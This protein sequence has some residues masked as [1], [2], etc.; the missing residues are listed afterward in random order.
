MPI[1]VKYLLSLKR[2]SSEFSF[3]VKQK[4]NL[5]RIFIYFLNLFYD[6]FL[7]NNKNIEVLNDYYYILMIFPEY[8]KIRQKYSTN[9][10]LLGNRRHI[11]NDHYKKKV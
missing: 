4:S 2:N 1:L 11:K 3:H 6:I 9:F 8:L 5:K 10:T 7:A